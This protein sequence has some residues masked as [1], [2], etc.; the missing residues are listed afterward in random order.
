M[1][2]FIKADGLKVLLN[3]MKLVF[4]ELI[5]GDSEK[6][7]KLEQNPKLVVLSSLSREEYEKRVIAPIAMADSANYTNSDTNSRYF[8]RNSEYIC[9]GILSLKILDLIFKEMYSIDYVPLPS[10][11]EFLMQQESLA[12]LTQLLMV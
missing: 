7:Q 2:K 12:T 5:K 11:R 6:K 8:K 10:N 1:Q 9:T 3:C 4:K